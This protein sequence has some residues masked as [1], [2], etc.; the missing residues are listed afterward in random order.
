MA[1][2]SIIAMQNPLWLLDDLFANLDWRRE[3]TGFRVAVIACGI[4]RLGT[5]GGT[6]R[7]DARLHALLGTDHDA[8]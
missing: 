6:S 5:G 4:R 3:R 8:G 2:A 7:T 1:M